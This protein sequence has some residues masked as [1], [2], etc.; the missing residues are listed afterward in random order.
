MPIIDLCRARVKQ[1][2]GTVLGGQLSVL[3]PSLTFM[4]FSICLFS[5][6]TVLRKILIFWMNDIKLSDASGDF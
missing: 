5:V 4:P 2:N 1:D 3:R 6:L